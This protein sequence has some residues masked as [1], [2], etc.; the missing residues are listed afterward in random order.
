MCN[1]LTGLA[2]CVGFWIG[3]MAFS[4]LLAAQP[5]TDY[6]TLQ[7]EIKTFKK[8]PWL[9]DSLKQRLVFLEKS[10]LQESGT[11]QQLLQVKDQQQRLIDS[12]RNVAAAQN[13]RLLDQQAFIQTLQQD[14][15]TQQNTQQALEQ[16]RRQAGLWYVVM[17]PAS[18]PETTKNHLLADDNRA[19]E[20]LALG[21]FKDQTSAWAYRQTLG[22][23]SVHL[24]RDGAAVQTYGDWRD[25][26][27]V[28]DTTLAAMKATLDKEHKT[29]GT[30]YSQE[31]H[32]QKGI[33]QRTG[34]AR[35]TDHEIFLTDLLAGSLPNQYALSHS[36]SSIFQKAEFHDIG[37]AIDKPADEWGEA[38]APMT[39]DLY[40]NVAVKFGL[41]V[42]A[43]DLNEPDM[44][45]NGEPMD[46]VDRYERKV[47]EGSK[48]PYP[49]AVHAVPL[50]I[51]SLKDLGIQPGTTPLILR[52]TNS[53]D[54]YYDNAQKTAHFKGIAQ[55]AQNRA[56]L[57]I[58]NTQILYK[59]AQSLWFTRLGTIAEGFTTEGNVPVDYWRKHKHE[60]NSSNAYRLDQ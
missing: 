35:G 14:L 31:E 34:Y 27:D 50:L 45:S 16:Q 19:F 47:A 4:G 20:A 6:K 10:I 24:C 5:N 48:K 8:N 13:Q 21:Y 46:F 9:Y 51:E 53:I 25:W 42:T 7:A 41:K 32:R 18:R 57:Y 43:H 3:L 38:D 49:F 2:R 15:L 40:Y 44:Y 29:K 52:A 59:P 23:A 37:A 26:M 33:V 12:L 39:H 30:E 56:V 17:V 22:E 11:N 55:S 58:F 28:P 1:I 36:L 60:R 54:I